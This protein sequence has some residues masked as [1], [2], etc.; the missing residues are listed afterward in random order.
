MVVGRRILG[1]Y[2]IALCSGSGMKPSDVSISGTEEGNE[3][4]D[5]RAL[6]EKCFQGEQ[7]EEGRRDVVEGVLGASGLA[8]WCEEQVS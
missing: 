8:G 5:W 3:D 2:V 6:G 7:G 4:G 1:A